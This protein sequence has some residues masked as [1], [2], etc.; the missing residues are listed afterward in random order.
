[1]TKASGES[2]TMARTMPTSSPRLATLLSVA[3]S[4]LAVACEDAPSRATPDADMALDAGDD[5]APRDVFVAQQDVTTSADI[6]TTPDLPRDI[7]TSRD[8]GPAPCDEVER[9]TPVFRDTIARWSTQDALGGWPEAPVVFVGSSSIRRWEGLARAYTD[10]NPLQRGVGGAQLGEVALYARE[11][12]TR[13]DPRAVVVYAGTNDL[14]AGVSA[15][16][17]VER[18]RCLRHR[19]AQDLGWDRPVFFI[20]VVP[21]P[22]RWSQWPEARAVNTAIAA[23]VASDPGLVYVDVATPFLATGSPPAASLFVSDGLHLTESGYALWNRAIRAA[24]EAVISP[25]PPQSAPSAAL[26]A[27]TRV[28]VDLG[29]NNAADGEDSP[30]PDH[31]GQHWNNWH[32]LAGGGEVPPGEQRINLVTSTGARTG[33]DLVVA[34]GFL[35]NG[36]RNGGLLWPDAARLG[37]L[38]VGSAT[39]DYFYIQD[40]DAPGA[41]F[42]RG[43]DPSRAYTFRL[44]AARD[45]TEVRITRYTLAGASMTSVTLQTSG[46]GAGRNGATTNDDDVAVVRGVRP[47]AWGHVFLDVAIERG[48]YAYVSAFELSVE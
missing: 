28:L 12:V 3:M 15:N 36:R 43:L 2:R 17:V 18:F 37:S 27:G 21:T 6:L 48:T 25:R 26:A 33:I 20:G 8:A 35:A 31:M 19:V 42:L 34:G 5:L 16:V 7:T 29:P 44:F 9:F 45:A 46:A 41:L 40:A 4:A 38:A 13:H 23:L 47:D 30:S 1:M 22:A 14:S 32:A 39:G 10:Y 11:L 24:L